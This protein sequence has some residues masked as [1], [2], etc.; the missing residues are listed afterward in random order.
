[1]LW[2]VSW[3][4]GR[5]QQRLEVIEEL[6]GV[7]LDHGRACLRQGVSDGVIL[8]SYLAVKSNTL[9]KAL[10]ASLNTRPSELRGLC[11]SGSK[12][13]PGEASWPPIDPFPVFFGDVLVQAMDRYGEAAMR[14]R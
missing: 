10:H 7:F 12:A 8:R 3:P 5:R 4:V 14:N 2:G 9:P 11:L 13:D 6:P 1:M